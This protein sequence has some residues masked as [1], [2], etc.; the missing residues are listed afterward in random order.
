MSKWGLQYPISWRTVQ[1]M[2]LITLICF[3]MFALLHSPA[4]ESPQSNTITM[5]EVPIKCAISG[6]PVQNCDTGDTI[7]SIQIEPSLFELLAKNVSPF[8]QV[9]QA[10]SLRIDEHNPNAEYFYHRYMFA[11][12]E[13]DPSGRLSV[14]TLGPRLYL[15]DQGRRLQ[16]KQPNSIITITPHGLSDPAI[17]SKMEHDPDNYETSSVILGAR[18]ESVDLSIKLYKTNSD[19][20]N[21]I[22][23]QLEFRQNEQDRMRTLS[24]FMHHAN[25]TVLPIM[26][27]AF[28]RAEQQLREPNHSKPTL[29]V[30]MYKALIQERCSDLNVVGYD[31]TKLQLDCELKDTGPELIAKLFSERRINYSMIT[32][33]CDA[34]GALSMCMRRLCQPYIIHP[35]QVINIIHNYTGRDS[36]TINNGLQVRVNTTVPE[37]FAAEFTIEKPG[38]ELWIRAKISPDINPGV[39]ELWQNPD[40]KTFDMVL[41]QI[42]D[43]VHVGFVWKNM[44]IEC[45]LEPT[46]RHT[47]RRFIDEWIV[48]F[49]ILKRIANHKLPDIRYQTQ[50]YVLYNYASIFYQDFI[51]NP[52]NMGHYRITDLD[53][54]QIVVVSKDCDEITIDLGR[55][56]DEGFNGDY[57]VR[58]ISVSEDNRPLCRHRFSG[59]IT[60][61]SIQNPTK[62]EIHSMD[63]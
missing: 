62:H 57:D 3:S 18:S 10:E 6:G 60:N 56:L 54:K 49:N 51:K 58:D 17:Y 8:D 46:Q 32:R 37:I 48:K 27:D 55:G 52:T 12:S 9:P 26:Q 40:N 50:P 61:G 41:R 39:K 14:Y 20:A 31:M 33:I 59:K 63:S 1:S 24:D 53:G 29:F 35:D 19:K 2:R 11:R 23:L 47:L 21:S 28:N 15:I 5:I 43:E 38:F 4:R 22:E 42:P 13:F 45:V 36:F 30:S 25:T 7:E 16:I 44:S 34:L